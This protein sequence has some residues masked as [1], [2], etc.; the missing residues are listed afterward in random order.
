MEPD[1]AR[2]AGINLTV[3]LFGKADT[4]EAFFPPGPPNAR[5]TNQKDKVM[6]SILTNT[7]AMTALK[8]L[9][10]TESALGTTQER[11]S[12]GLKVNSAKDDASTWAIAQGIKSDVS[13]YKTIG[14]G[15]TMATSA[16]ETASKAATTIKDEISKIQNNIAKAQAPGADKAAIQEAIDSSLTA[17]ADASKSASF[18]GTNLVQGND[19]LRV[20][21][22]ISRDGNGTAT[23]NFIDV[24]RRDLTL[25]DGLSMLKGLNVSDDA[26]AT[27]ENAGKQQLHVDLVGTLA[28]G[29]Q[30]ADNAGQLAFSYT[31][32]NGEAKTVTLDYASG[33]TIESVANNFVDTFGDKLKADGIEVATANDGTL[34]FT[35][36]GQGSKVGQAS[37][38]AGFDGEATQASQAVLTFADQVDV[39]VGKE[40]SISLSSGG[41]DYGIK[42]RVVDATTGGATA[43]KLG[44]DDKGNQII[45]LNAGD[46]AAGTGAALAAALSNA[47]TYA[48]GPPPSGATNDAG[49]GL[50]GAAATGVFG[51]TV[52]GA[53]LTLSSATTTDGT[54]PDVVNSFEQPTADFAKLQATVDAAAGVATSAAQG[55][56][57]AQSQAASQKEFLST[58]VDSLESGVGALIDADI[59]AES[60]R[61]NAL[62]T[63]QQLATQSL[64]IANQSGQLVLSLFR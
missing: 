15:L 1:A 39:E 49:T 31:S 36:A 10:Q 28:G 61:L 64:S 59:T 16:L 8:V 46:L 55:F 5:L 58:L 52:S 13:T 25:E 43:S 38:G 54:V 37:V 50:F 20:L 35:A 57:T 47:L 33:A 32:S 56:G 51:K 30:T 2:A 19:T 21:S 44:V 41:K 17:I 23:A 63:Q 45:A 34:T 24:A 29:L 3:R 62:Q 27:N 4:A 7:A 6:T 22:S 14:E 26:L 48:A 18:N 12:T 53:S 40:F 11:I 9:R 60:S 42:V